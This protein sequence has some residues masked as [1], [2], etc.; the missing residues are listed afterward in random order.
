MRARLSK[1]QWRRLNHSNEQPTYIP[2]FKNE[3]VKQVTDR[4][5]FIADIAEHLGV[6][7]H[8]LYKWVNATPL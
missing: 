5:C 2:E 6:S 8:G 4:G 1:L 3:A 7:T